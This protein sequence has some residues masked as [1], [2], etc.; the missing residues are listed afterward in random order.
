MKNKPPM[1]ITLGALALALAIGSVAHAQSELGR[2]RVATNMGTFLKIGVGG[3]AA[4]LGGAFTAVADDPTALYWNPAGLVNLTE[5][6]AYFAHTSWI[7]DIN[8]E[9]AAYVHPVSFMADGVIGFHVGSLRTEMEET[10]EYKPYGTGREF[11]YSDLFVGVAA[12]QKFT[13][14]LSIGFG[15]KYI[16]EDYGSAIGAPSLNTW[17]MDFGSYYRLGV[18]DAIFSVT[19]LNFGPD[20]QPSGSFEEFGGTSFSQ[21]RDYES[22]AP[23]ISFRAA[24]SSMIWEGSEFRQSGMIEMNR[25]PDNQETYLFATE[26]VYGNILAFRAGYNVKA[27]DLNWSG[28]IGLKMRSGG[29]GQRIDYGYTGSRY[30]GRVDRISAGVRF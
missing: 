26:L 19:L 16:H 20:W 3:K 10:T 9:Y 12:A 4:G 2:T 21:D 25:P 5:R 24:A 29:I 30:L 17:T 6:E 23:P 1:H 22:F 28:G 18:N 27:D 11:T 7:A 13:D 14:K 8:Y 15:F